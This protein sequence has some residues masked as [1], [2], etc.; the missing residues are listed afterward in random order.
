L[1][2]VFTLDACCSNM[3]TLAKP[4]FFSFFFCVG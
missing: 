3:C 2:V 1:T 4:P